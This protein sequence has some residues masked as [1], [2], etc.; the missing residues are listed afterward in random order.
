VNGDN[1]LRAEQLVTQSNGTN[2]NGTNPNGTNPNGGTLIGVNPVGVSAQ[3]TPI[4]IAVAGP[5][6]AGADLVGS[7]WTGLVSDGTTVT[8]RV[9]AAEQRTGANA[10]MWS[11]QLSA[12]A[13]GTWHQL[14]LDRT[15]NPVFA[16]T[17]TGTWNLEH[18]VPGGGSYHPETSEFSIACRGY[19]ISECMELGYKPWTG[20]D[21]ELAA[22]VRALRA[23]YCGDGT[24]YTVDGTLVN[25]FDDAGVQTDDAAWTPEAEWTPDGA[26]CV[27]KKEATRFYQVAHVQPW[28]YPDALED[29]QSC[30]TGF[31]NGAT[32]IT[33]LAP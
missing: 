29:M 4:G 7:T 30:G 13:D 8:L 5:P 33:E 24:P 3:G 10:D 32:I 12:S 1:F 25:I 23:D 15:G 14:C 27:S 11:Y 6:L 18:G 28:C 20:L 31:A 26:T 17:V 21:R 2:P 9:D 19:S 22:C 16:D